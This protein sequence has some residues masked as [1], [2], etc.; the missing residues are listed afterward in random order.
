[1]GA[2]V[3]YEAIHWSTYLFLQLGAGYRPPAPLGEGQPVVTEISRRWMIR[4]APA[5]C[6]R[7]FF[8][9][10]GKKQRHHYLSN[11][12]LSSLLSFYQQYSA[13]SALGKLLA[14]VKT[15]AM[16]LRD[17][18]VREVPVAEVVPGDMVLLK[19]GDLLPGDADRS[20]FGRTVPYQ[21]LFAGLGDADLSGSAGDKEEGSGLILPTL[22]GSAADR[23]GYLALGS[24]CMPLCVEVPT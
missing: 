17:G 8:F 22:A 12:F 3:F 9:S 14:L 5:F 4:A 18:A 23:R 20:I 15:R 7:A 2:I 16:V 24:Y 19:A 10:P 21:N 11:V 1:M 13:N 6:R